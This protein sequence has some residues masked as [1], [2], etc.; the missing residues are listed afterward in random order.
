MKNQSQI[1][2]K[3]KP[4]IQQRVEK[5]IT[6]GEV[7]RFIVSLIKWGYYELIGIHV[8]CLQGVLLREK[9]GPIK[10]GFDES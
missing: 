7:S 10:L 4:P 3:N 6:T 2:K 1:I 9:K 5:R 8:L